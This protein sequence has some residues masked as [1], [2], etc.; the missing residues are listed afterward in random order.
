M[1]IHVYF[2]KIGMKKSN[3]TEGSSLATNPALRLSSHEGEVG[4]V[5]SEGTLISLN[6][7][8]PRRP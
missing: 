2:S 8:N 6:N 5:G 3:N 7:Q 1:Q 4:L